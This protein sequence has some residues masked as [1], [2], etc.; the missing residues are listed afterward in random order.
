MFYSY[1]LSA[2]L[3]FYNILQLFVVCLQAEAVTPVCA[4]MDPV[5]AFLTQERLSAFMARDDSQGEALDYGAGLPPQD[6]Q[7]S[8]TLLKIE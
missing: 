6:G 1:S 3:Y 4:D 2:H 5:Q 7:V 8:Y